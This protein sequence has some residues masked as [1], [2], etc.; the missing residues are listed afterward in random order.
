MAVLMS[1]IVKVV[2]KFFLVRYR[3]PEFLLTLVQTVLMWSFQFEQV[4]HTKFLGVIIN[5][6]FIINNYTQKLRIINLFN[7]NIIYLRT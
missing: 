1:D 5:D 6:R 3:T 4:D 7:I 2:Y